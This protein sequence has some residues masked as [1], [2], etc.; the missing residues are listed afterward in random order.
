[1]HGAFGGDPTRVT[2]FGESAGAFA[3]GA[4][5]ASPLA[6]GLFHRAILQSGTGTS[7]GVLRRDEAEATGRR[8]VGSLGVHG[9]GPEAAAALR[10]VESNRLVT[11]DRAVVASAPREIPAPTPW[12]VPFAPV[13]DGWALPLPIDESIT[14][15]V[16]TAVPVIVGSNADEGTTFL[17]ETP[18]DT[19]DG[20]RAMLGPRW[21]W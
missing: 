14:R 6:K 9:S 4:L 3:V 5:I 2:I 8:L 11:F 7:S 1:M 15:R 10:T 18:V 13:D 21:L 19:V 12:I 17:R 20:F 16:H